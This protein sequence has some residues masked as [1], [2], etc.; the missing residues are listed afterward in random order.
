M[1][2]RAINNPFVKGMNAGE[3]VSTKKCPHLCLKKCDHHYCINERLMMAKNGN[4]KDGLIFSGE[5][6]FKMDKILSVAE[7]FKRFKEQAESVYR[8]GKGFNPVV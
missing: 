7:I 5:N 4:I 6:T 3:D 1:P 2:G 8:E